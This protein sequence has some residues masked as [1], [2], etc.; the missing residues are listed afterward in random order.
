M[1]IFMNTTYSKQINVVPN[2]CANATYSNHNRC[3]LH[4]YFNATYSKQN[5]TGL[6]KFADRDAM[7]RQQLSALQRSDQRKR[8]S[9]ALCC[10]I[11]F[12]QL[13]ALQCGQLLSACYTVYQR[14]HFH[15]AL[16]CEKTR[17]HCRDAPQAVADMYLQGAGTPVPFLVELALAVDDGKEAFSA[18]AQACDPAKR[19][20]ILAG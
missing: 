3:I 1:I 15:S 2:T 10:K 9:S 16:C 11:T 17:A 13:Q 20:P 5:C 18:V 6:C 14:K 4:S 8:C 7:H 12:P 19:C